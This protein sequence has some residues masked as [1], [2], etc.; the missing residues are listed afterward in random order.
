M[1]YRFRKSWMEITAV[2][3]LG[4]GGLLIAC[5][6]TPGC[7]LARATDG[8]SSA[9]ANSTGEEGTSTHTRTPREVEHADAAS[10]ERQV[11]RSEVPVLVDFYAD[12]CVPCRT[13]APTLEELA[14]EMPDAKIVKVNVDQSP[15][16]AARYRVSSIPSLLVFNSGEVTA[17]HVGVASKDRLKALL[18]R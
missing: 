5:R 9:S 12:W 18:E 10:F 7:P 13:L 6:L 2:S 4:V 17:E 16:L 11:L 14:R 3:L 8:K 1:R 15:Q